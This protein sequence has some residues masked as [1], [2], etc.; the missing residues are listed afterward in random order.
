MTKL[1]EAESQAKAYQEECQRMREILKAQ[2]DENKNLS[3]KLAEAPAPDQML[4]QP[5]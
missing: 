4:S 3:K 2:I 5:Q 1:K